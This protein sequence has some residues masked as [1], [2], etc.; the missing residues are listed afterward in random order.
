M[1]LTAQ[2]TKIIIESNVQNAGNGLE[3]ILK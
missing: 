1:D 2:G 3:T